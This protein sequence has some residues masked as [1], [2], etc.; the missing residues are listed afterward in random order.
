MT[1]AVAGIGGE[2]VNRKPEPPNQD[3]WTQDTGFGLVAS[4][5][6][7]L[8]PF[9]TVLAFIDSV[10]ESVARPEQMRR[11]VINRMEVT[12]GSSPDPH[13]RPRRR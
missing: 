12:E 4:L 13:R 8:R 7:L 10:I 11:R 2:P 6:A 5:K 1:A 9:V 3:P